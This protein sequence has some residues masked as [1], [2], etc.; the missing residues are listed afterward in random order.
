MTDDFNKKLDDYENGKMSEEEEKEFEKEL[1]KL[2]ALQERLDDKKKTAPHNS[3]QEKKSA[4]NSEK[5]ILK[6]GKWSARLQTAFT[7]ISFLIII[8]IVSSIIT[9]LYYATGNPSRGEVLRNVIEYTLIVTD[10]Y[11]Q[12]RGTSTQANPFFTMDATRDMTKRVGH[13]TIK[14]GELNYRFIFSRMTFTDRV[15]LG[16]TTQSPPYMVHPAHSANF[17]ANSQWDILEMLPEGTVASAYVSFNRLLPTEEVF[18]LFSDKDIDM[19]WLAVDSGV[20]DDEDLFRFS[21]LGFPAFMPIW[22]D[23][24][25]IVTSRTEG[26]GFSSESRRSPDYD[27]GDQTVFHQQFM[28][29]LYFLE[30][31]QNIADR[32]DFRPLNLTERI[33][34][35]EENGIY[36]YGAV[37]TGPTKELLALQGEE[38]ITIL[39]VDEVAFWNWRQY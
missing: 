11:G 18:N 9:M 5:K 12:Y 1:E 23:D 6:R 36:H 7:A 21:Y 39:M 29:T 19:L 35:L 4:L 20:E 34:H 3:G 22:H 27:P 10:P 2:E 26:R 30:E 32:V 13:E 33:N 14:V 8:T 16:R 38:W 37:I 17:Q 15:E 24:D 28:K 31:N 25:M